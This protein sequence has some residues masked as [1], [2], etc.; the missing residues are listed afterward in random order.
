MPFRTAVFA[1]LF[2]SLS[3]ALV[4]QPVPPA[5]PTVNGSSL[6]AQRLGPEDLI[7]VQ[8]YN[9]PELSRTV[10]I[11][12]NGT[13]QLPLLK[14]PIPVAGKLPVELEP[15][16]A[17]TL[18]SNDLVVNPTVTVTVIE[19]AGRPI[20]VVGAVKSPITFQA[21]GRVTLVDAI[22][23][24]GGLSP[25]AG[26]EILVNKRAPSDPEGAPTYT[27]HI[28]ARTLLSSETNEGNIVLTGNEE[29]RVPPAGRVYVVG[30]VKSP[31]SF[32][33][34]DLNDTTV[35]KALSLS[36]G[37]GTYYSATAYIVR[38]DEVT[39]AKKNITIELKAILERKV[40]DFPLLPD[41]ILFIPD[42][43]KR[44][45]TATVLDRLAT[46]GAGI[47]SGLAIYT[48]GR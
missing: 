18:R 25:E 20:S 46:V 47:G 3:F 35:L 16:I 44:R 39:G 21:V 27:R 1:A 24:A 10:R 43:T 38:R 48:L 23:R 4:A 45:Q 5:V 11:S 15:L 33:V 6:P 40:A 12:G 13:I 37:L 7:G 28:L 36:G 32:A 9:F 22:I 19:Y 41:D 34:Q 14:T 8:V 2:C 17:E 26:P 42:D 31:G 29:I 30:D